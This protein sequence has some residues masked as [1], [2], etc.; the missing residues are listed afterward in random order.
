[1]SKFF[2][3]I[4]FSR[5]FF[6]LVQQ[7]GDLE[8]MNILQGVPNQNIFNPQ[9]L[10]NVTIL[11]PQQ[12]SVQQLTNP[13][14]LAMVNNPIRL[15]DGY[16]FFDFLASSSTYFTFSGLYRSANTSAINTIFI[17]ANKYVSD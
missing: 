6:T 13:Q 17:Y 1:M 3:R 9:N 15:I 7:S 14:E 10:L 8:L 11:I 12:A 2:E 5:Y 16:H 4:V